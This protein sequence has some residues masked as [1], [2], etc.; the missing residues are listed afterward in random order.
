MNT[1]CIGGGDKAFVRVGVVCRIVR[2]ACVVNVT[3]GD[4]STWNSDSVVN[5]RGAAVG[6][7]SCS[8]HRRTHRYDM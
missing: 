4:V 5:H 1:C 3:F 8:G 2:D 6:K 7:T